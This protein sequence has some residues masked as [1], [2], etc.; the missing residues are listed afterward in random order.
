[1]ARG[2]EDKLQEACVTW[3]GYQYPEYA[4]LLWHIPNGGSRNVIEAAK[5]KRMG[6]RRGV[7]D[8]QLAIPR[9]VYTS[10]TTRSLVDC[11]LFIELKTKDGRVTPEQKKMHKRLIAQGYKVIVCRSLDDFMIQIQAYIGK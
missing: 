7:P 3:F 5:L 6:V 10:P 9:S 11:G 2:D 8:L 4:P 1:M